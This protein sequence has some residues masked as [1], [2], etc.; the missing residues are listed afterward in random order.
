[1]DAEQMSDDQIHFGFK[2]ITPEN[3]LRPGFPP[4]FEGVK[5]DY[6]LEAVLKPSLGPGVPDNIKALYEV[7]RGACAYA[8]LFY[9]LMTLGAH[10]CFRVLEGAVTEKRKQLGIPSPKK[11]GFKAEIESL[12]EAGAVPKAEA[13][14]WDLAREL[15]NAASHL[16]FQEIMMPAEVLRILKRTEE[17]VNRLFS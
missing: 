15:R 11:R 16:S 7:A 2:R 3:W 4:G 17:A 8:L 14:R 9:P 12:I 13:P 10:Q 1:M 6:W 5:A